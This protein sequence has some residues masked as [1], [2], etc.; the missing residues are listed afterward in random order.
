MPDFVCIEPDSKGGVCGH[1][2]DD[3][4]DIWQGHVACRP[5]TDEQSQAE[6]RDYVMHSYRL[7]VQCGDCG[8]SGQ[9]M[10]ADV[11]RKI[12]VMRSCPTCC[13]SGYME[14]SA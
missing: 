2:G 3:H 13:G 5:C 6:G 8:G 14:V 9:K 4:E 7:G 11:L 1:V 12:W 10:V